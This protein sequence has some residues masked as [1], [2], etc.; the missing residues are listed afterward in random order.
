[1]I[2][3]KTRVIKVNLNGG[4]GNQ[5][6][7]FAAA[8]NLAMI[9]GKQLVFVESNKI[10]R[11]RLNFLGID[12]KVF[13]SPVSI[14]NQLAL[15]PSTEDLHSRVCRYDNYHEPVFSYT[16]IALRETHT[17]MHGY[18]QSEKYFDNF[19]NEIRD[20]IKRNLDKMG[21]ES[22]FDNILQIRMGDMARI[23]E[24]RNVHGIVT[25][26]YLE[27]ALNLF[28]INAKSWLQISDDPE[29]IHT[30]LPNFAAQ[31]IQVH[32]GQSD[33]ED[34]YLL[35]E[36]KNIIISNSTFG[37]WG[38]WLSDGKVVAPKKWF[39]DL[40]LQLR[41]TKDLFPENWTLI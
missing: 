21:F 39:S 38:A 9:E 33:I 40:G 11:N 27:N 28:A 7:Q 24:I 15:V 13:Y 36:A 19:K 26:D 17:S 30:E 22:H 18:F 6:F 2:F 1:M 41:S 29:M 5:L 14:N 12:L 34:L 37:W 8:T 35:S 32:K 20:F 23:A 16:K 3:C 10:W 4:L 31:K 25:D